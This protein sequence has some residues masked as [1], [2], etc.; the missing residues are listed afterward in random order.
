MGGVKHV[1]RPKRPQ[2]HR[3]PLRTVSSRAEVHRG[4]AHFQAGHTPRPGGSSRQA[5]LLDPAQWLGRH[6][7]PQ[8]PVPLLDPAVLFGSDQQV[9]TPLLFGHPNKHL[10]N[11]GLAVSHTDQL[12]VR[13]SSL[14]VLANCWRDKNCRDSW[15]GPKSPRLPQTGDR[16]LAQPVAARR[17]RFPGKGS[18]GANS[19]TP[20][21]SSCFRAT[22][23]LVVCSVPD[24][25]IQSNHSQSL[26][27]NV[28]RDSSWPHRLRRSTVAEP[29]S[30]P[31]VITQ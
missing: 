1:L 16:A 27:D 31:Q 10:V 20:Q 4:K 24:G 19:S 3:A 12:G 13:T 2:S 23:A 14:G 21:C 8:I 17:R 28:R 15:P 30:R 25:P 29:I 9:R 18:A 11:I 7:L 5:H 22:R 26:R 6:L